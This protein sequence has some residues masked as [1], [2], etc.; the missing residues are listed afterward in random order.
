MAGL[1]WR[2]KVV[3]ELEP[4]IVSETE[5]ARIERA[6]LA[7]PE[8]L[9]LTLEEG[10][11]LMAAA[12][13]EIV[14]AQVSTVGERFRWCEHCGSKLLSKGHYPA[15][16]RS[17]FGDV[18]VRIRRLRACG[19]RAGEAEQKSFAAMLPT[20][21]VAPELAYITAKFAALVP[22][23][24]VGD[25]FAELLP[26]GGAANAGT[27]RNR[28]MRVGATIATLT[29]ADAPPLEPEAITP[30]VVV[31]VDGGY[32]RSRHRRPERNF[33]VIA[34][35]VI[36]ASGTQHRFAFARN[37]GAADDFARALVRAGV[38]GGTAST[39]RSDG[40]AGLWNLQRTVLP[41]AT[42]VLDWFHIAMRFEHVLR[43]A[44]GV[45]A[46][47]VDAHLGAVARRDTERAKWCLWHGRWQRCLVKLVR[48]YRWAEAKCIHDAAGVGTLRRH[49][50]DLIDYLEANTH[51]LVNYGARR[52]RGEPISTA[53]VESAVNEIVSRRMIKKQQMRWNRWTVQ[54]FL[55]VRAAVLNGTLEGAFRRRYPDFRP[56]NHNIETVAAA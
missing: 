21:G 6:D 55:D 43:A 52:R 27:V 36:D 17:V 50:K 33:E 47:T 45:G 53:F 41:G 14:R 54:P 8:T 5:V 19:C 2:V 42:V 46:G 51:T 24:R 4:G 38:R 7:V 37:G 29:A 11:Q 56:A 12:Q 18:D 20:G 1:V 26:V 30:A 9:G 49:L 28:T 34:G 23:A 25:L 32:V 13:S 3:A 16:F 39:V 22:F 44:T 15:T 35:K 48:T 10:K 40:D 31:G